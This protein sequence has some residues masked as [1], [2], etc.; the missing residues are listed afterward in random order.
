MKTEWSRDRAGL[1]G[2][3]VITDLLMFAK[4]FKQRSKDFYYFWILNLVSLKA[5]AW[6]LQPA[7]VLRF[8]LAREKLVRVVHMHPSCWNAQ[9]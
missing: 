1:Q 9:F 7:G 8:I 2:L 6:K 3:S 4:R 5:D